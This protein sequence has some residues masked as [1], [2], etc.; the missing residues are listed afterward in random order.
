MQTWIAL[1]RGIN[2]GKAKR[3]PMAEL[4]GLLEGLGYTN[5]ATLLNSG[6]AV[7]RAQGRSAASVAA[8][9][10]AAI[11][12]RF[13]FE[14]PVVIRTAAELKAIV[15][16]NPLGDRAADP[17]RTLVAFAGT[18]EALRA[19]ATSPGST[20]RSTVGRWFGKRAANGCSP[21]A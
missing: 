7:F 17:S 9:V 8:A 11:A 19:L 14:V 4:R 10:E 21:P 12:K 5:V 15:R 3:V 13:G 20:S 18:P 16:E 6:N 1:L 2:V